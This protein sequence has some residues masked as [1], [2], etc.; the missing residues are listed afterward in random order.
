MDVMSIEEWGGADADK[1]LTNLR[2]SRVRLG[3]VE[4]KCADDEW[5]AWPC[6]VCQRPGVLIASL[7]PDCWVICPEEMRCWIIGAGLFSA[8]MTAPPAVKERDRTILRRCTPIDPADA[9]Y[10]PAVTDDDVLS[11]MPWT[12]AALT[13][14]ERQAWLETRQAAGAAID[15][16]T[17]ELGCW[18]ASDDGDPYGLTEDDAYQVGKHRFVR[19]PASNG[20]VHEGDL[21]PE[22]GRAMYDRIEAEAEARE[23]RH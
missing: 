13:P 7:G 8:W 23:R 11:R 19:S 21:P 20:W 9:Q 6:R 2:E 5:G 14:E 15:I 18:Y 12:R 1:H 3:P 17:C 4:I 16:Q 10:M 22:K